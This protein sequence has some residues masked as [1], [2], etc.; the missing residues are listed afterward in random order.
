MT[1][2]SWQGMLY[3]EEYL[4]HHGILGMKHGRRRYQNEDGTW[5]EAG[6]EARRKREGFGESRAERKAAKRVAKLEKKQARKAARNEAA[7]ARAEKRRLRSMKG[8]TDD[9]LKARIAR[10]KLENEYKDLKKSPLLETGAKLVGK[11]LEYKGNKEQREI[12]LNKQKIEFERIKA[13]AAKSRDRVKVSANEA[14]KA[15]QEANKTKYDVQGGL[16]IARKADLKKAKTDYRNTTILGGIGKRINMQ[17]TSGKAKEYEAVRK[18]KGESKANSIK[19]DAAR[20]LN[21][22]KWK[23]ARADKATRA[24]AA[25]RDL[26]PEKKREEQLRKERHKARREYEKRMQRIKNI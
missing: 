15:K 10:L 20:D 5:T 19:S 8:L 24:K 13:D 26:R 4:E 23:Q 17:L 25:E 16:K 14:K 1:F 12:D 22:R 9:E 7:A 3:P 2:D 21:N 6:L 18:A 11:Y